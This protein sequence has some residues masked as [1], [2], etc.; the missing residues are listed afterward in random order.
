MALTLRKIM[1]RIQESLNGAKIVRKMTL[2]EQVTAEEASTA[3][4]W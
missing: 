2:Q 3:K 4:I 1:D